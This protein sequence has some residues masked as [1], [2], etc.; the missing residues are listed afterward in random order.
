[1][2]VIVLFFCSLFLFSMLIK[3][4]P[5]IIELIWKVI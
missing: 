4:T 5:A 3:N 2:E 1:M